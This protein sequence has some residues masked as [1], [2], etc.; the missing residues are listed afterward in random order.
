MVDMKRIFET[1]QATKMATKAIDDARQKATAAPPA[2]RGQKEKEIQELMIKLQKA[3]GDKL[4]QVME[5]VGGKSGCQMVLDAS[6]PSING[7]PVVMVQ[8]KLPDLSDDIIA[9]LGGAGQ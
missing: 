1:S 7:I 2:E 4:I 6:G 5:D 3:I 8:K 9:A